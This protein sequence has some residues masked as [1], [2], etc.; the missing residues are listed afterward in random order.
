MQEDGDTVWQLTDEN[1]GSYEKALARAVKR[2][3]GLSASQV[4]PISNI[5]DV[6]SALSGGNYRNVVYIGHSVGDGNTGW[7]MPGGDAIEGNDFAHALPS[8]VKRVD[9]I[10]C[11]SDSVAAEARMNSSGIAFSGSKTLL[12]QYVDFNAQTLSGQVT[13]VSFRP[14][15]D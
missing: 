14:R 7:L 1:R 10:G 4:T 12:T 15:G 6:N 5:D 3:L 2:D 8:S 9:F 11:V 13:N